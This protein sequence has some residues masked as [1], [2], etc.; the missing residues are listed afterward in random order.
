MRCRVLHA[1]AVAGRAVDGVDLGAVAICSWVKLSAQQAGIG[2]KAIAT[3]NDQL[4]HRFSTHSRTCVKTHRGR[5]EPGHDMLR[6][7]AA[8]SHSIRHQREGPHRAALRHFVLE[9][10]ARDVP[11]QPADAG[12]HRDVLPALCV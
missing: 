6:V 11:V 9:L 5:D 10:L 4:L 1:R 12:Q 8:N 2:V 7:N 3:A